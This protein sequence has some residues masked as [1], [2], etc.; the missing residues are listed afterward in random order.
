VK[1][2]LEQRAEV[3]LLHL[4]EAERGRRST[5]RRPPWQ[6]RHG[7]DPEDPAAIAARELERFRFS[8]EALAGIGAVPD[9]EIASWLAR[10]R[11]LDSA[12][13]RG[14]EVEP[15]PDSEG[16][17]AA[18]LE[19]FLP[20]DR[21]NPTSD[22]YEQGIQRFELAQAA[23]NISGALSREARAHWQERLLERVAPQDPGR[24]ARP[25]RSAGLDLQRV[26]AVSPVCHD[27]VTITHLEL[28]AD[29]VVV[30]WHESVEYPKPDGRELTSFERLRASTGT[31]T[32]RRLQLADDVGTNYH[33]WPGPAHDAVFREAGFA[34]WLSGTFAPAVP[35]HASQLVVSWEGNA[36]EVSLG[37]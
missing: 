26:V 32:W 36:V 27:G 16:R 37:P 5:P 23:V 2:V 29:G 15:D 35:T 28:F 6:R 21:L 19:G 33:W 1:S 13:D 34:R 12:N 11:A 3:H 30:H 9:S 22:D 31:E 24:L 25:R 8:V 18:L 10:F 17:A 14:P 7:L 20:S 4:I